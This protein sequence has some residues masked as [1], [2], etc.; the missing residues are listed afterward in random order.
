MKLENNII[1]T[2]E[3]FK[4]LDVVF[5]SFQKQV[6][7]SETAMASDYFYVLTSVLE[8]PPQRHSGIENLSS[9]RVGCFWQAY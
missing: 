6:D 2:A 8:S 4:L 3:R 5:D 9:H 7:Y 1:P